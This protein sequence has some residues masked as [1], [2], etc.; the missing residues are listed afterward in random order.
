MKSSKD[1][2]EKANKAISWLQ[3]NGLSSYHQHVR[4]EDGWNLGWWM[5][6]QRTRAPEGTEVHQKLDAAVPGWR[7]A[8]KGEP[9]P[10]GKNRTQQLVNWIKAHDG[11]LPTGR[12]VID[13]DGFRIGDYFRSLRARPVDSF[14][15]STLDLLNREVPNW[16]DPVR[17][18]KED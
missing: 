9:G 5:H 4:T 7:E 16:R 18:P 8:G 3:S 15:K 11:E 12:D 6:Y 17:K 13:T 14:R 1:Q 2:I 10:R